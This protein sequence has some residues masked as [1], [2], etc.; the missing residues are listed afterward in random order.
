MKKKYREIRKKMVS[1]EHILVHTQRNE[2]DWSY[3]AADDAI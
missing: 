3:D 2:N 1:L